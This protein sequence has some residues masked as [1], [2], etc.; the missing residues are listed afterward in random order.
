MKLSEILKELHES[1]DCGRAVEGYAEKA[2]TIEAEI[3]QLR[4]A[5]E[6]AYD[7]IGAVQFP[8]ELAQDM[9]AV[10]KKIGIALGKIES[11]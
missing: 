4:E 1:G 3:E 6:Q 5:L 11:V 10:Y 9:F 2:E 8:V 7:V